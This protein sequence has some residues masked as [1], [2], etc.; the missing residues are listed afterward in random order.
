MI[1]W[2]G[3]K[4][5]EKALAAEQRSLDMRVALT[6]RTAAMYP[7]LPKGVVD[8]LNMLADNRDGTTTDRIEM[9]TP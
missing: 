6:Y 4:K 8:N 3:R 2:S 7:G 5:R 9:I 1:G